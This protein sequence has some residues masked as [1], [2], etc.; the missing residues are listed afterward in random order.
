[1]S[2]D[3]PRAQVFPRATY[4][5]QLRNGVGFREAE[6][7]VPYL[8]ALGV[9]H[10]Y[11]S[12][13]MEARADSSHGYDVVDPRRLDPVLGDEAA[14][15]AFVAALRRHG[16][17]LILDWVPNH[18]GIA[19]GQN[20]WWQEL[21]AFGP[22]SPYADFFDV[23]WNPG[24]PEL[25]GKVLLP[26]LGG[27]YGEVL[28]QGELVPSRE[29][30]GGLSIHY[31]EHRFPV[32]PLSW[33]R[34][35][36]SHLLARAD[37]DTGPAEV[38]PDEPG[39][40]EGEPAEPGPAEGEPAEA[41]RG[42]LGALASRAGRREQR[43]ERAREAQRELGA[44]LAG[45]AA[46]SERVD[47]LV[48][49]LRGDPGKPRSFDA[50]HRLLQAQHY[51]LAYWRVAAEEIN[52]RRFFDVNE[53]AAVR[54]ERADVFEHAHERLFEWIESGLVDGLR[55][56]HVDGLAD[57]RAYCVRVRE[58]FPAGRLYFVVEKI[59]AHDERLPESW[60]VHGTTGYEFLN[61]LNGLFI[62]GAGQL[63][64]ARIHRSFTGDR[65]SFD[66]VLRASK[67]RVM[68][69]LLAS[70]L[71]GLTS[72]LDRLAQADRHTRD[73][74][75]ASLRNALA[76]IVAAFP[77]Y[78]SYVDAE[79]AGRSDRN[80]I[81]RAVATARRRSD[82]PESG[83]YQWIES[84][85]TADL[86]RGVR[87]RARRREVLRFVTRFQQYTAPVMAKGF[88]DTAL[89]R[90]NRLVSLNE[91]GG[92]P[93]HFRTTRARFHAANRERGERHPGAMLCTSTHDTKRGEDVRA[94]ID[95]LS[96]IPLVWEQ[97][98]REWVRRNR[99]HR[100]HVDGNPAPARSD[101][102]LLYQV[103]VGTFPAQPPDRAGLAVYCERVQAYMVKALREGKERSSWRH[104]RT[105]YEAALTDFIADLLEPDSPFLAAF[106][107]FAAEVAERGALNGLS[108]LVLKLTAPG[109]PDIYQG[110]E[111]WD[112]S[113]A[114]P[115]NRR[116]VD[117]AARHKTLE[118][119]EALAEGAGVEGIL[120]PGT[121]SALCET[122]RDGRIKH[123]V[124]WRLLAHR[125]QHPERFVGAGYEPL[126]ASGDRAT[127]LCA[128]AR[129][130]GG[131]VLIAVVP[132]LCAELPRRQ[133]PF[134][135]GEE[136]WGGTRIRLPEAPEGAG[137]TLWRDVLSGARVEACAE[138]GG[139]ALDAGDCFRD[140]PV[141][142]LE[143]CEG[144]VP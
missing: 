76:E 111:D 69:A 47:T 86:V 18:V 63:E 78:R 59:L 129:T 139:A 134:P 43:V 92:D 97:Q 31:Y 65:R 49:R 4:R 21:L 28:E 112:L 125:Q 1:M 62:D 127:N 90:F 54:M 8:A 41:L 93:R 33:G 23:D 107:P 131:P 7:L 130:A 115:D 104:P 103:L 35:L 30:D 19:L 64:L 40:A 32:S 87:S 20:P 122:W 46:L 71:D 3:A 44:L 5:L 73:F 83:I 108:Q 14:F 141:A 101:E 118:G 144:G 61:L 2:A 133:G 132:R 24:R 120:D 58:R 17:G 142:V 26:V 75:R 128:L 88:E 53:L 102:Y 98:L 12:P 100:R 77:V 110:C 42:L 25:R 60:P 36:A 143:P 22:V 91:V 70:E 68:R 85:L 27:R 121:L 72:A 6:A 136:V 89:Y 51:R 126:G 81:V 57:P 106:L 94:R 11:C 123:F 50:L 99:P 82:D 74:T 16:M 37:E 116:P 67:R 95:V 137:T 138:D 55:V 119:L 66:T 15:D 29:P 10:V 38:E 117:F 124:T 113:L 135:L 114:D 39:P 80:A 84:V 34:L 96:E 9:S 45:N 52:Y 79:G 56:D 48:A 140:L 13:V 105:D 109:V